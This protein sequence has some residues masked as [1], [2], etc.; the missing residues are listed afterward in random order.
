MNGMDADYA[1][2]HGPLED[3]GEHQPETHKLRMAKALQ[4]ERARLGL[5][6]SEAAKR[7]GVSKSTLSQLE[8]GT[9]NPSIETMW[10]L[11]TAY[12][13][14]IAQLLEPPR[15]RVSRV[16]FKD[17][18][19]LPSSSASYSAALLSPGN[20]GMRRDVYVITA[21]PGPARESRPHP[22]GTVEHL[23]LTSGKARVVCD[24]ESVVLEAGDFLTHAGDLEHSFEALE[25]GTMVIE[26]I[27]S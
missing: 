15:A 10:A 12:G 18:P 20:A 6:L 16:R 8:T 2:T 22:P 25:P 13:V 7:A 21:E 24:G 26:V 5:S 4:R 3:H 9:G 11:A 14:Q 23:L 1:P 17:L 27:D 19:Q